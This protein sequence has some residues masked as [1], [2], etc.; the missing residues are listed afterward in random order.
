MHCAGCYTFSILLV[1]CF[2]V[3]LLVNW[4]YS[5]GWSGRLAGYVTLALVSPMIMIFLRARPTMRDSLSTRKVYYNGVR[6]RYA[7]T[8]GYVSTIVRPLYPIVNDARARQQL[9]QEQQKFII[10]FIVMV[11]V[12][13]TIDGI[14]LALVNS[15]FIKN[16]ATIS[17]KAYALSL[18]QLS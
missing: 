16:S 2:I 13:L 7:I 11:N 15:I 12:H 6:V 4:D 17:K 8:F 14:G 10:W 5:T 1:R 18:E 3:A 9:K